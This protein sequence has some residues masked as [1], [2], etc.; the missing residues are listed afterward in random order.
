M[1]STQPEILCS[2][3]AIYSFHS[4]ETSTL[5]FDRGD[6]IEVFTKLETGWWNGW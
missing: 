6:Q 3:E 5:N 2:V 4:D 1:A